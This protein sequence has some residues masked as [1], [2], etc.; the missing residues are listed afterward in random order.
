MYPAKIHLKSSEVVAS[1]LVVLESGLGLESG[2][3]SILLDLDSDLDFGFK[4]S[5]LDLKAMDL[6]LDSDLEV[7][8]A[9]HFFKSFFVPTKSTVTE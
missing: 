1:R 3:K 2:L 4:D 5:D 8:P 6:D 7:L 9:S